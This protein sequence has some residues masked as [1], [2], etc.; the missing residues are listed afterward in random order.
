MLGDLGRERRARLHVGRVGDDRVG[1]EAREQVA[2]VEG[3]VE[4]RAAPAFPRATASASADTSVASTSRS[5]RS[6]FSASAMAPLPVPTS[7][8]RMP[9]GSSATAHSTSASVSGRGMS[10]RGSTA[11]SRWRKPLVP[12]R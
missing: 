8:T 7:T 11:S 2:L 10:T 12:V 1:G 3:D 4:A 6:S 5:G 9:C